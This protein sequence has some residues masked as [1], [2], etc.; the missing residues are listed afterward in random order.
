MLFLEL[1]TPAA[2]IAQ[3]AELPIKEVVLSDG[4]RRYT[5]TVVLDGHPTQVALDTGSSGLRVLSRALPP[6]AQ[7]ISGKPI[8]SRFASGTQFEGPKIRITVAAS[9]VNGAIDIQRIDRVA[10]A[11]TQR[12]CP[13]SRIESSHFKIEGDGIAGE[14]FDAILGIGIRADPVANP[15][16]QLGVTQWVVELPRPGESTGLLIINPRPEEIASYTIMPEDEYGTLLGCLIRSASAERI[17]GRAFFDTGAPGIRVIGGSHITPWP[18]GTPAIIAFGAG[19]K[20]ESMQVRIGRGE[21]ASGMY[22]SSWGRRS[23]STAIIWLGALF[24][25]VYPL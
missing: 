25:L 2:A 15:L 16:V 5:V 24:Q 7:S 8:V 9:T 10:C 20:V 13:A 4:A 22:Y 19:G 17:C 6:E 18:N 21:Q 3:R 14:G 23:A 12:D 1:L 11:A